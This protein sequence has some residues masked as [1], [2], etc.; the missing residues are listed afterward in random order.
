MRGGWAPRN[1]SG[2]KSQ[3]AG[4]V[5]CSWS[6]EPGSWPGVFASAGG[7]TNGATV[8]NHFSLSPNGV[9]PAVPP[10]STRNSR[11]PRPDQIGGRK[12]R[13][14]RHSRRHSRRHKRKH[15]SRVRHR[16]HKHKSRRHR[17]RK[18]KSRRHRRR[19]GGHLRPFLPQPIA[20]TMWQAGSV[21]NG[22]SASWK[23]KVLS[24]SANPSVLSQPIDKN[25]TYISTSPVDIKNIHQQAGTTAASL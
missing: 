25:Y 6:G 9:G 14:R 2:W 13:R 12:G 24:P 15:K 11:H 23:G 5:G 21:L 3:A 17:Q 4:P 20:N 1:L 16:Q 19:G 22:L 18:H 7:D 10:E 8:S